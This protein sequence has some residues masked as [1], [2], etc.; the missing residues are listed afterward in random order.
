MKHLVQSMV[1]FS[2]YR[3]DLPIEMNVE[4]HARLCRD[5]ESVHKPYLNVVGSYVGKAEQSVAIPMVETNF[6][7]HWVA[8]AARLGQE[9]ILIRHAD[10]SCYLVYCADG[11]EE[12]IG[13]WRE[14]SETQANDS[15]AWSRING[16]YY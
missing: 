10:G 9:S 5:L 2:A 11:R 7:R 8:Y 16:R 1:F 3:A 4:R 15:M 6:Y 13:Q 12:Y 14:V